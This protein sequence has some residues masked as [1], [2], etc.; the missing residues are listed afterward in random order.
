VNPDRR[1]GAALDPRI[2][3]TL[4]IGG[5][6]VKAS[7]YDAGRARNVAS[8][9]TRYPDDPAAEPG[10]FSPDLWW[11]SALQ[12]CRELAD[13][14]SAAE[15]EY[16]G[17]TVSAIRIPFVL[18]DRNREVV[19]PS[20][21]NRDRR[22]GGQVRA[23]IRA[24]GERPLY[25]TTGHWATPEFGL[26]KLLWMRETYPESWRAAETILQLH[27]WFIYK[28]SGALVSEPSS[29]AMSQLM[30]VEAGGWAA[31]LLSAVDVPASMLPPMAPA[32][33][34][35]GA[36]LPEV[37]ARTGLPS[38]LPVHVGGGDTHLSALAAGALTEP[39]PVVVAGTTGPAQLA[40]PR[41]G[42]PDGFAGYYPLLVSE[43]PLTRNRVLESN[44]GP[45]GEIVDRL[46]GF[47]TAT[48][49]ELRAALAAQ[50]FDVHP[51]QAAEADLTVLAGNP[52]FGP[53]GWEVWPP[54][55]VIGLR[56]GHRGADVRD[57]ALRG[58]CQAFAAIVAQLRERSATDPEAIVAAGGMSASPAWNAMLADATG[59]PVRVRPPGNLAGL[60]GAALVA[61]T[62]VLTALDQMEATVYL[63]GRRERVPSRYLEQF[64]AA[65]RRAD[66]GGTGSHAGAH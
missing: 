43:Q 61:G 1:G 13:L 59:Q 32:G 6:G 33:A 48:G 7:A 8:V 25:E 24:F 42:R 39:V 27:D 9:V 40:V 16:L 36:L 23:L 10:T 37:A 26:P 35:A 63:P 56:P 51:A 47:A 60:A 54:P 66:A 44:A 5:S 19:L 50:G 53:D 2:V 30:D 41:V 45:T 17:V 65:Q 31:D 46:A 12:G 11:S 18:I 34:P 57:A 21:L 3:L 20:L 58:T 22:A 29:A 64:Q 55:A 14:T 52:C 15:G 4:D 28:L 38:G 62:D 49:D